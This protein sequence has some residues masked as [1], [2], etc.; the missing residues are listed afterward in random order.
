MKAKGHGSPAPI[1][2]EKNFNIIYSQCN[3]CVIG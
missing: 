3:S 1:S 2:S